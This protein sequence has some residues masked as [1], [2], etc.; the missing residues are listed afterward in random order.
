MFYNGSE[1]VQL[2]DGRN[3]GFPKIAGTYPGPGFAAVW[4]EYDGSDHE[5]MLYDGD[6]TTQ[7]TYTDLDES[8]PETDGMSIVWTA[9]VGTWPN[10]E[11]EV[12]LYNGIDLFVFI[13]SVTYIRYRI[14][15]VLIL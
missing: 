2:S 10:H 7:I 3:P 4:Y 8:P 12:F 11:G 6:T 13:S 9:T 5:I 14:F 1:V 15:Y